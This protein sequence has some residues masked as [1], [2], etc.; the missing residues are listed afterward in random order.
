LGERCCCGQANEQGKDERVAH[1][2]IS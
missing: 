1:K 2:L